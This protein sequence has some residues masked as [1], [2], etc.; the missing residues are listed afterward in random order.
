MIRF[1]LTFNLLFF[2]MVWACNA[3]SF[4]LLAEFVRGAE[5]PMG[6]LV[7]GADGAWYGTT[8][9]GGAHGMGTVFRVMPDGTMTTVFSFSGVNGASPDAGLVD[10]GDGSLYGVT[11]GGGAHDFGTAF[12]LTT[13]GGVGSF[14]SLVS[15]SGTAGAVPGSIPSGLTAYGSGIFYGVTRAGGATGQGTIFRML[16]D[17]QVTSLV[18]FTGTSGAVR[19][20]EPVGSLVVAGQDL[21]GVTAAGGAGGFGTVYKMT[22]AGGWSL[23]AEFTGSGGLRPGASPAGG[24]ALHSDGLLYGTT[25]FGGAADLGTVFKISRTSTP[26]MTVVRNFDDPAGSQ[27]VGNLS[28]DAAGQWWGVTAAGGNAGLGTVFKISPSGTHTVVTHLTGQ[29]GAAP[30][31][32][33][34]TGLTP[35]TGGTW[36]GVTSAG[37]PGQAG[38][39]FRVDAAGKYTALSGFSP[40]LGSFPSGA[41]VIE[42]AGSF[43]FPMA[44]GGSGGLGTLVRM[45]ASTAPTVAASFTPSSGG[46]PVGAL[47]SSGG[48]WF[49]VTSSDGAS[50][51]GTVFSYTP[52]NGLALTA[53]MTS[54]GGAMAEGPLLVGSGQ[55]LFGAALDGGLS[56]HGT[57]FR[58]SSTGV[59]TRLLSFTGTGGSAPGRRPRGPLVLAGAQYYGVTEE[60]GAANTGTLFRFSPAGVLT[61][62]A[63][64]NATGPRLPR[65]GLV[66]GPGGFLY[67]STARGGTADA[68]TLIRIDPATGVWNVIAE[69]SGAN[70]HTP[71]G[72]LAVIDSI[73]YGQT[74]AG[75]TAGLGVIF[76]HTPGSGLTIVVEFTGTAGSAPGRAVPS[77]EAGATFT[78]GLAVGP[79]GLVYGLAAGG[80]R[81]GGG[82]AFRLRNES[83]PV[84]LTLSPTLN[85]TITG[86]TPG[87]NYA[88]GTSATLT[89]IPAP[90]YAF[91]GWTGAASGTANPLTF[92]VSQS[93]TIGATFT[94]VMSI[95]SWKLEQLGTAAVP[96][97][98]DPDHDGLSLLEEYALQ[99]QAAQPDAAQAPAA[100]LK[101]YEND[102]RLSLTLTRDPAR[103]DVN[104]IVE[105]A[106]TLN[107]PWITLAE[108]LKG[109]PFTGPGYLQ[110]DA[111]TPGLKQV[112]I[113]D[114][115]SI[116]TS[117]SRFARIKISH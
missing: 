71:T 112:E 80:G 115:Q 45:G 72:P 43:L 58:I 34:R 55:D 56:G 103:N 108:S 79:D 14:V 102:T 82:T 62:L 65:S 68:G 53:S 26:A 17:G 29:S 59:R 63:Q 107:G 18:A 99:L 19:G 48:Q 81:Y 73:I 61:P 97:L 67:G 44:M 57:L 54:T 85:G 13:A 96:D 28:L 101:A 16:A 69:F 10:G 15:F 116:G 87:G 46:V 5:Q 117:P 111:D 25:E 21:Y 40:A 98:A 8:V 30:G 100:T 110:G 7:K 105:A 6:R 70:G 47:A 11:G 86:L 27:P 4:E 3:A 12:K 33:P 39:V 9:S 114:I 23:M 74:A 20:A 32:V 1:F 113:R 42:S 77:L 109:A 106:T 95:S 84:T 104:V 78:G 83:P 60:G 88:A 35:D 2:G 50:G 94:A 41:P 66:A 64:F 31:A 38:M 90:G 93:T 52:A 49:G 51:R 37:G 36:M 91:A 22:A 89:A 92:P 76:R 75:G 24:L